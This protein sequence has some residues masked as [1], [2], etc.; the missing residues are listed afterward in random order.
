MGKL[1]LLIDQDR[2]FSNVFLEE[3]KKIDE[4]AMLHS[5]VNGYR[6]LKLLKLLAPK[7]PDLIF[8]NVK[9]PVLDGYEIVR[10]IRMLDGL[11][12]ATI[13][14]YGEFL[15]FETRRNAIKAGANHYYLKP[16]GQ[17][18]LY[19]MIKRTLK[20]HPETA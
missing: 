6:A 17:K 9:M 10:E 4:S 20:K 19:H 14:I 18:K 15:N 5:A 1:V 13:I 7:I 12:T 8:V 2:E 11:S 3:L 16:A